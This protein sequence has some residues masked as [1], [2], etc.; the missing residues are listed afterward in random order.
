VTQAAGPKS[1]Q[2]AALARLLDE[3]LDQPAAA[4]AGWLQAVAERAPEHHAPLLKLLASH[5][6]AE[7]EDFLNRTL[8]VELLAQ[9]HDAPAT[10]HL[11]PYHL[12]RK[13]GDGA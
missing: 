6:A 4:L 5:E 7:A 3:A 1:Q 2:L 12:L 11:G 8:S 13:L 9:G 10:P